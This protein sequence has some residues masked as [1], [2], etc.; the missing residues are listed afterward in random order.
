MTMITSCSG[1]SC[2]L[3]PFLPFL[4]SSKLLLSPITATSSLLSLLATRPRD[5]RDDLGSGS[6]ACSSGE[7]AEWRPSCLR[8][9]LTIITHSDFGRSTQQPHRSLHQ[10]FTAPM[11]FYAQGVAFGPATKDETAQGGAEQLLWNFQLLPTHLQKRIVIMSCWLPTLPGSPFEYGRPVVR[12]DTNTTRAM[13]LVCREYRLIA[14]KVLFEHIR[15][16][17]PST[18]R[19]LLETITRR[20][21]LGRFI[22]SLHIGAEDP[23]PYDW[24]PVLEHKFLMLHLSGPNEGRKAP[25]WCCAPPLHCVSL[26]DSPVKNRPP[27]A[28]GA[29]TDAVQ[30]ACDALDVDPVQV[31]KTRNGGSLFTVSRCNSLIATSML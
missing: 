13:A 24:W 5:G 27:H 3:L 19:M 17:R 20:P 9:F 7:R 28:Q 15:I 6:R 25:T 2:G 1:D 26:A 8:S 12:L 21:A 11:N 29:L 10:S 30:A 14:V 4:P 16:T 23:L 18:L 22:K 31:S